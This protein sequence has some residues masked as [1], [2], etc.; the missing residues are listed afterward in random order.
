M[1]KHPDLYGNT[2]DEPN[3]NLADAESFKST[4]KI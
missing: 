3:N 1:Q 4:I 2:T